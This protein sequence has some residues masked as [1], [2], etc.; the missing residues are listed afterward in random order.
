MP[1]TF[2]EI[3]QPCQE[4]GT[5]DTKTLRQLAE[6]FCVG[7]SAGSR[8]RV[9]PTPRVRTAAVRHSVLLGFCLGSGF[10]AFGAGL[11]PAARSQRHPLEIWFLVTL[12]RGVILAAKF[13]EPPCPIFCFSA[14]CAFLCHEQSI[15]NSFYFARVVISLK[16]WIL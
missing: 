6:G 14:D 10:H 8:T 12:D 16:L 7:R 9:I 3:N 13:H 15:A 1:K 11:Y 4:R 2:L 5:G